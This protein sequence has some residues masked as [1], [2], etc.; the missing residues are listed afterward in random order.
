[1]KK[2]YK[3]YYKAEQYVGNKI[4]SGGHMHRL[5]WQVVA[6]DAETGKR[7][8]IFNNS[9]CYK[10]GWVASHYMSGPNKYDFKRLEEMEIEAKAL[11]KEWNECFTHLIEHNKQIKVMD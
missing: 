1:M 6:Y 10:L 11:E 4:G 7:K 8:Y 5:G 9:P 3:I 2:H